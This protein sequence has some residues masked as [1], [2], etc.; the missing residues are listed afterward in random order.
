MK[1]LMR[2]I[3][4]ILL[5]I[6]AICAQA[7]KQQNSTVTGKV[8]NSKDKKPIDY[9]SVAI[10]NLKDSSVVS[11]IST[12][13]DGSFVL[14]NIALGNYRLY[15]AFLGLKT[16]TKD[17]VLSNDKPS[18]NFGN[19]EM[20]D[21]GLELQTVVIRSEAPPVVVKKDT[22]EFNASSFKVVENAVVEDV[23]KK[24]PGVEV[25][26]SGNIKAQGESVTR[27]KVDGKDFFGNDP[28]LATKNL[29]A[30][31]IDKIQIIDELSDQSKFTGVDDGNRTKIINITTRKGMKKGYFGN[32]TAGYGSDDKYEA[33]LN[34]NK[35]K[36]EQ[37]M[38]FVGQMNNVNKQ[39][40]GGGL[41]STRNS[42]A[43]GG[44]SGLTITNSAGVNFVDDYGDG[45]DVSANYFFNKT[46]HLN[47]QNSTTKNLLASGTN[48]FNNN[49]NNQSERLNHRLNFMF[50][51]SIDT[52][53]TIRVQPEITYTTNN[54]DNNSRYNRDYN[55]YQTNGTQNLKS[56]STVPTISNNILVRRKFSKLGRTL[57]LNLSTSIN[58]NSSENYNYRVEDRLQNGISSQDVLNQLNSQNGSS[59][60]QNSRLVYT[61]PLSKMLSLEFNYSNGYS[62]SQSDRYNYNFNPIT[63]QYDILNNTYTNL[64]E[65]TVFT[66]SGG[67][68]FTN[69]NTK[70][71]WNVGLAVQN[72]DRTNHNLSKQT[73]LKQ[74]VFNYTPSAMFRY[75]FSRQKRL[76]INYR[77]STTQPTINQ[78]QPIPDNTNTSRLPLGNPNLKAEYN[79]TLRF[80][81]NNYNVSTNRSF[82]ANLNLTQNYNKIT[83]SFT[84]LSNGIIGV[85]PINVNGVY[86]GTGSVSVGLPLIPQNKLNLNIDLGGSYNRDVN[87]TDALKNITNSWQVRNSYRLVSNF[88][89]VDFN[90]GVSGSVNRATYSARSSL[91][92]RY[93]IFSPNVNVS[94][95]FPGKIRLN[96]DADY[97]KNVGRGQGFDIDYT[98]INAYLSKQF[99]KNRGTFKASVNDV[100]NQNQGVSRTADS[101]TIR[102]L[103][104]NVLKR[105]YMFSFTYAL[106]RMG[107][108]NKRIGN[109]MRQERGFDDGNFRMSN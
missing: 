41:G 50:D 104:F 94:Y 96:V 9:A 36:Q 91:N 39:N 21:G 46:K 33:S 68:S 75:N 1:H 78:L 57:S 7:Q 16:V 47:L 92:I 15:V 99:L 79:N 102:D 29:P 89:N 71:I 83:N 44:S 14:K 109:G 66:N 52:L 8:I 69:T 73:L 59:I 20:E 27:V 11:G 64:Y 107:A 43:R 4:T 58:D 32:S 35:F 76:V 6:S 81:Y 62:F 77:G 84:D 3:F 19:V 100:L 72:T 17:F 45:T 55:L 31:M 26:K 28:L 56:N 87:F 103:T 95:M 18:I 101:S 5:I 38:S 86:A 105:Y 51:T 13:A 63:N 90:I 108:R 88:D 97:N 42:N 65:N 2:K 40:F 25:D 80:A 10:K 82:F 37:K 60:N 48:V 93:Y 106:N 30:D 54:G 22:L 74:S 49:A 98:L 53:T 12:G 34:V 24:L 61:E 70:Y 67:F 85:L 23:L